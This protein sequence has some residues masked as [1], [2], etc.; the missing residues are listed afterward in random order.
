M[1]VSAAVVFLVVYQDTGVQLR[2]QIDR[3]ITGDTTQLLQSLHSF[4]GGNQRDFAAA[5]TNYVRAQPYT[6][7]STVLFVLMPKGETASNHP[8][9]V[10]RRS[11]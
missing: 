3:D 9:L 4:G 8:E 1:V 6:A 5:A 11:S 2:S 10:R 7:T